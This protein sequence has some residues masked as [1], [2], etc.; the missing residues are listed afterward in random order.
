MAYVDLSPDATL[1]IDC[2]ASVEA[3]HRRYEPVVWD[4][5]PRGLAWSREDPVLT[6]IVAAVATELSRVD[7][8]A[9]LLE[10]E[11]NPATTWHLL[12]DW[13]SHLSL[14]DCA[15]PET[16]EA[17]RAA[18]ATKLL[19]QTGHDQ[20]YLWWSSMFA[21]LSYPLVWVEKGA[22]AFSCDSDCVDVIYEK[23]WA[24]VW[25]AATFSGLD[26]SLLECVVNHNAQ[27]ETKPVVHY[28]WE[29]YGGV[30]PATVR[31]LAS[32]EYGYAVAMGDGALCGVATELDAWWYVVAPPVEYKAV[33]SAAEG[34]LFVAVGP[35]GAVFLSDNNGA[36]WS[37]AIDASDVTAE[38]HGVSHGHIDQEVLVGV[39]AGGII[40][41]SNDA[42]NTWAAL[43]SPV[44]EDLHAVTR[45]TGALVGV[46]S[47]G[48][49]IRSTDDGFGWSDYEAPSKA[50]LYGVAAWGSVVVAVGE[51]GTVIRSTD[52]GETW[53]EVAAVTTSHLR[54]VAASPSGRWVSC[55]DGGALIYSVDHGATWEAPKVD[56]TADLYAA[57]VHLP[58]GRLFVAGANLTYVLE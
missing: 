40:V 15:A 24:Y 33:C 8:H 46:G 34:K 18:V 41:R 48:V 16:I 4:L 36:T 54:A 56:T 14:P 32:N 44:V 45:C 28:L 22:P 2:E 12:T 27:I 23:E 20:G 35:V 58:S 6:K 47:A 9:A 43:T 11:L 57:A 29:T 53:M 13:E 1:S 26:D 7:T 19:A 51:D 3:T 21:S 52:A 5:L 38:L 42:G 17:R 31:A 10:R 37:P 55:G 39:G 50:D 49:I 30:I 25:T